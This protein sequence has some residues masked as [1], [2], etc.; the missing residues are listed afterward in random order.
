MKREIFEVQAIVVDANGTYSQLSGY[1]KAFDSRHYNNDITKTEMR[2]RGDYYEVLGAMGKR[3]D[4][5]LQRAMI[6]RVSDGAILDRAMYGNLI[7]L[8]DPEPEE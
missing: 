2:A 7:D 5:Q 3:D 4:R 1:P 6:V 8:P